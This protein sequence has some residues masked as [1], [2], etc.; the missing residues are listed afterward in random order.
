MGEKGTLN[1][2]AASVTSRRVFLQ[3][4]QLGGKEGA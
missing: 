1:I 3:R 2:H 4:A